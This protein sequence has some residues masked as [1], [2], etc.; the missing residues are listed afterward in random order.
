MSNYLVL[1][2]TFVLGC[3]ILADTIF[4]AS[5]ANGDKRIY[6]RLKFSSIFALGIYLF[7]ESSHD[8]LVLAD[9]LPADKLLTE[10]EDP[11]FG[12]CIAMCLGLDTYYRIFGYLEEYRPR[13]YALLSKVFKEPQRRRIEE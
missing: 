3:Y 9:F 4:I 5:K 1:L 8:M 12:F 10:I 11:F 2:V 7:F 13:V 6:A